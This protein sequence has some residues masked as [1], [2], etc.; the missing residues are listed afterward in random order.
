[1][2]HPWVPAYTP[3]VLFNYFVNNVDGHCN[4]KCAGPKLILTLGFI[5]LI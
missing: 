2:T 4:S 3:F 1:M 5:T